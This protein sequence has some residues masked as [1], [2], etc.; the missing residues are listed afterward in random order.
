MKIDW[1][2]PL[3]S[4]NHLITLIPEDIYGTLARHT[5]GEAREQRWLGI[6]ALDRYKSAYI[7]ISALEEEGLKW[8]F[9]LLLLHEL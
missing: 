1:S 8:P 9:K 3:L 4:L 7:H 6:T 5:V 2:Q